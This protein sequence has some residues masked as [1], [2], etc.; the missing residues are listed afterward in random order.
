MQQDK[1]KQVRIYLDPDDLAYLKSLADACKARDTAILGVLC[2]AALA[3]VKAND[4]RFTMPLHFRVAEA[5]E[6][7]APVRNR[8]LAPLK[9]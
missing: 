8:N 3:A 7:E 1:P 2:S 4:G 5:P 9:K 6:P